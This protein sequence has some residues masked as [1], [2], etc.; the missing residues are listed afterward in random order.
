MD[1]SP[2]PTSSA[3]VR[4]QDVRDEGVM[5]LFTTWSKSPYISLPSVESEKEDHHNLPPLADRAR[6]AARPL[7]SATIDRD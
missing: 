4:F 2:A 5:T 3:G 1:P 6:T 7:R